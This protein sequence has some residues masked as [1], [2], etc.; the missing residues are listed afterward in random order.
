MM[1]HREDIIQYLMTYFVFHMLPTQNHYLMMILL[2]PKKKKKKKKTR[3]T[4]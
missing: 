1:C 3:K 4:H 2:M